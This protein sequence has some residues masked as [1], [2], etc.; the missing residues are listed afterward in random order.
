MRMNALCSFLRSRDSPVFPGTAPASPVFKR[1]LR[2]IRE[3]R[4]AAAASH[5]RPR[6]YLLRL[7]L[8]ALPSHAFAAPSALVEARQAR[9]DA[10]RPPAGTTTGQK[11]IVNL[12]NLASPAN[13]KLV[14]LGFRV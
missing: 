6:P 1:R 2:E 14:G 12:E 3:A 11:L 10:T 9:P 4:Q 13:P 7:L 5:P 8:M